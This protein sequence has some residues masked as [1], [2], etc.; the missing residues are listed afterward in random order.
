MKR[1]AQKIFSALNTQGIG[2][3]ISTVLLIG[4]GIA[5]A[6][7]VINWGGDLIKSTQQDVSEHSNTQVLCTMEMDFKAECNCSTSG[8]DI[9]K[10]S[11]RVVNNAPAIIMEINYR[12]FRGDSFIISESPTIDPIESFEISRYYD[13]SDISG[14]N[15][16]P[17]GVK[18]EI[19]ASQ[20]ERDGKDIACGNLAS[21][22][23]YCTT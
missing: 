15:L 10:C 18:L 2:P 7:F 14:E 12:L 22:I 8:G 11:Y 4:F 1:G 16:D 9:D 23:S 13:V 20:I 19:V 3:L 21:D 6:L 5:V 17:S